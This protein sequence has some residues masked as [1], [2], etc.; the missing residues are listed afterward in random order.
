MLQ[1]AQGTAWR[2][3]IPNQQ[4]HHFGQRRSKKTRTWP[5]LAAV[6]RSFSKPSRATLLCSS[7]AQSLRPQQQ[8]RVVEALEWVGM[9]RCSA[10]CGGSILRMWPLWGAECGERPDHQRTLQLRGI[11]L[12]T[13]P[14]DV[15]KRRSRGQPWKFS[16][17]DKPPGVRGLTALILLGLTASK[18]RMELTS[19]RN[20]YLGIRSTTTTSRIYARNWKAFHY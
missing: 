16:R 8:R 2:L 15:R 18:Y 11:R 6:S 10:L 5:S 12:T 13:T 7:K 4:R 20:T 14:F 19:Q 9:L 1:P 3:I 17:W